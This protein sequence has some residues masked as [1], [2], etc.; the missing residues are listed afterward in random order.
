MATHFKSSLFIHSKKIAVKN[1]VELLA[2]YEN[3]K[4]FA[5]QKFSPLFCINCAYLRL[6]ESGLYI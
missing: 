4:N 1:F 2:Y 6:H 5:L 3:Y